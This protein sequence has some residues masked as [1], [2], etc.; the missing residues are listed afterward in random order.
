MNYLGYK[1]KILPTAE[2]VELL[3][4]HFGSARFIY[5]Y[6]LDLKNKTYEESHVN[7]SR[8]DLQKLIPS[9]KKEKPW[10]KLVNSQTL[11]VALRDLDTAY[12]NFFEKRGKFPKF[13]SKKSS[14]SRFNVPQK[15]RLEENTLYT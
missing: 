11:Q 13:K 4:Q 6:F 2:Q 5:N 9:L 1:Y 7:F 12:K 15:V 3:E 14:Y 10:L 8:Y